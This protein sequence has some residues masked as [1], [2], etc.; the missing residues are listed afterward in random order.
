[1]CHRCIGNIDLTSV[2][3]RTTSTFLT[4]C[5]ICD[6][7]RREHHRSL[8]TLYTSNLKPTKKPRRS[9]STAHAIHWKGYVLNAKQKALVKCKF[10]LT[11]SLTP[12]PPAERSHPLFFF[13]LFI[14]PLSISVRGGDLPLIFLFMEFSLNPCS[15]S[16][17][18]PLYHSCRPYPLALAFPPHPPPPYFI[19]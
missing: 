4:Y 14:T 19:T 2:N 16:V 6:E 13:S 11:H 12:H 9:Q 10:S 15:P 1:M 5:Q 3:C 17:F 18:A 8:F 7:V